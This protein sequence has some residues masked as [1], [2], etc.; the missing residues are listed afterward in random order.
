MATEGAR[1]VRFAPSG[2]RLIVQLDDGSIEAWLIPSSPGDKLAKP[3]RW[4]PPRNRTVLAIGIGRRAVLAAT[5]TRDDPTALEL[6]HGSSH[7]IRMMLPREVA[8]A[9]AIRFASREPLPMG[10]CGMVR[11]R[12][13]ALPAA[14]RRARSRAA[15]GHGAP[16]MWTRLVHWT[17]ERL[18]PRREALPAP[19]GSQDAKPSWYRRLQAR[20]AA[21]L[22]N[23]RLGMALGRRHA[24]YLRRVLELF[25][26]GELDEALRHAIPLGGDADGDAGGRRLGLGVPRPRRDLSLTFA[27]HG[28]GAIIPV[29]DDAMEMMRDRYR[30]AAARLEQSG[31]IDEAAFVFAELLGDVKAAIALLERHG[32]YA[33]AAR[34]GE[35]RGVEPA[36][37]VRLW[38]LAGDGE[39]AI[40]TARRHGAWA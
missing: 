12:R 23:S 15:P 20:I 25:D 36:L 39:R 6:H 27:R 13:R 18:A 38:F 11:L 5:A 35:G 29:A 22:W 30:A 14:L 28:A 26:R 24:A 1:D 17:S 32:R 10:S 34:L 3:R 19:S 37:V 7:A 40:D 33:I 21:A 31:R 8:A 4:T 9:L 16:S 2:D